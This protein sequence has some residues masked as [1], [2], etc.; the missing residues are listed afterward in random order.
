MCIYRYMQATHGGAAAA[1][2]RARQPFQR[3]ASS[4]YE[5]ALLLC[6]ARGPRGGE[7]KPS[8]EGQA[9]LGSRGD[10]V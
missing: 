9:A 4:S 2:R 6:R 5:A 1:A 8:I 3:A 7:S 10:Q